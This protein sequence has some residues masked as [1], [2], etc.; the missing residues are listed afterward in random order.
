MYIKDL[1]PGDKVLDSY[2]GILFTVAGR[3]PYGDGMLLITD[4]VIALGAMDA[5]EPGSAVENYTITGNSDYS[6]SN[7]HQWLNSDKND[8]FIPTHDTD[9]PPSEEYLALRPTLYDPIGHNAYAHKSGFLTRFGNTFRSNI[10]SS[11]IPCADMDGNGIH[12]LN[13]KVFIPSAAE[14]GLRTGV[15]NEGCE[16]PLFTDFCMRYASPSQECLNESEWHPAYFRENRM[17]WYWLRTPNP[18]S[19]GFLAFSHFTNPFSFKFA[20]SPWMGIRP[21]LSICLDAEVSLTQSSWGY[22]QFKEVHQ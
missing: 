9:T 16:L 3:S 12:Y 8:W 10:C 14:L 13:T 18:T 7:L 2:S 4:K 19:P 11:L 21:M 6:L 5:P 22:Y 15:I 17:I 1:Y 20:C